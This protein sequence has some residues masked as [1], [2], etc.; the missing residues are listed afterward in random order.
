MSKLPYFVNIVLISFAGNIFYSGWHIVLNMLE[1]DYY[2]RVAL[3]LLLDVGV[4][5]CGML[6]YHRFK[7]LKR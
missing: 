5:H 1:V 6:L 2:Q 7:G 4:I 3:S